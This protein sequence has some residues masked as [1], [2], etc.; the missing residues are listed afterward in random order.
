L[1]SMMLLLNDG[2]ENVGANVRAQL[3]AAAEVTHV[4]RRSQ[5]ALT[6]FNVHSLMGLRLY[7]WVS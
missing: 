2:V 1:A 3:G 4:A 5:S 7:L 6:T